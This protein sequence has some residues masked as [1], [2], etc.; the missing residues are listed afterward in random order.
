MADRFPEA[1][2]HEIKKVHEQCHLSAQKSMS[3]PMTRVYEEGGNKL[4]GIARYPI[5][6]WMVAGEPVITGK[7][8]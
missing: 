6:K 5:D 8:W 2:D 7:Q 4:H 3:L 1:L